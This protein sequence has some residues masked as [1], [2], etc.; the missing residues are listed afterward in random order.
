M[1]V[2][3]L[4]RTHWL[5]LQVISVFRSHR[6]CSPLPE[7]F[8]SLSVRI[9]PPGMHASKGWWSLFIWMKLLSQGWCGSCPPQGLGNRGRKLPWGQC[10]SWDRRACCWGGRGCFGAACQCC[11]L[12]VLSKMQSL[13]PEEFLVDEEDDIFGEG[14]Y[15][16]V[17]GAIL[18]CFA[19]RWH[20][21][22]FLPCLGKDLRTLNEFWMWWWLWISI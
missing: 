15:V 14:K 9:T 1:K 13:D 22:K 20:Y 16:F 21:W 18:V 7:K 2:V 6:I 3:A 11:T 17:T 5:R 19:E 10:G 4:N 8:L 12:T